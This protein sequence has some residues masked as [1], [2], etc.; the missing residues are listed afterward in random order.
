MNSFPLP[1]RSEIAAIDLAHVGREA[2]GIDIVLPSSKTNQEGEHETVLI[3]YADNETLCPIRAL[4]AWLE[5]AGIAE[6]ALFR[7]IDRHGRVL[8]RIQ[9]TVVA[10]IT[11]AFAQ[12]AKLDPKLF[13]AHSL[14]SGWISTAA[15]AGREEADMM[16]HS[17]HRSLT[18]FRGY[19]QAATKW[20]GHPGVGLL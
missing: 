12:T 11:K 18:V 3:P 7:R 13:G 20:R 9:P 19:V 1:R 15:D 14:R 16:G 5:L 10:T 6:G 8:G 17:R 4:D 2:A